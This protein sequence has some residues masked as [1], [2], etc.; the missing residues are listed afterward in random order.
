[1]F[2]STLSASSFWSDVTNYFA[3]FNGTT[4]T[5]RTVI[6]WITIALTLAFIV[7]KFAVK[8]DKQPLVNKIALICAIVYALASI[9]T[10]AVCSFIEDD[11]VAISF[12]PLLVFVT[13]CVVGALLISV[14][15]LKAV[16]IAVLSA[17]AASFI[18][19]LVCLIVYYTSGKASEWNWI[20][21]DDVNSVGLYIS[22]AALVIAVALLAFFSDRGAQGFNSR[23]LSF[24]AV[25]VALSFALSYVRFFKMPMGGSITFASMLPIMLYSYM[26]GTRKGVAAGLVYG[27]LQAVQDPWI[28]H[29]AQF[30]LDYGV[31]FAAVGLTGCIRGFKL[32]DGKTRLQ[33]TLGAI[34]GGALRFVSHYFSGVFAFGS[35]G[36]SFAED[37]GIPAL[38]N[39]YFYSF[40]YQCLYVIPEIIIVV[41][42]GV[43]LLSSNNFK[44]QVEKYYAESHKTAPVAET[45]PEKAIAEN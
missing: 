42:A 3:N 1:M 43:I 34:I 19:V 27:V 2:L 22:A 33:F 28:L 13:V 45:E 11:I 15:P 44:R 16:K 31:A 37:Y 35:A 9:I 30:L 4:N 40:V 24:A 29:P 39:P 21:K 20:S 38:T 8:K 25:C 10:F 12:Y 32:F 26:F 7:C 36:A 18:A 23:S 17:V 14:K 6:L 5:C 41:A